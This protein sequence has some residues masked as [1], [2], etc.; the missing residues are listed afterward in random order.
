M[1]VHRS[2][3]DYDQAF[4]NEA[5]VRYPTVDDVED[6]LGYA[7]DPDQLLGAARVLA[8]P[9]K[10]N[11]P[12]WQH[13]RVLYAYARSYLARNAHSAVPM[14]FLDIGTAK[15]F[16]ALC[17]HWALVDSGVHGRVHTVDVV[18]PNERAWRNTVVEIG[19][20][21]P[22]NLTE[23]LDEWPE[24]GNIRFYGMTGMQ[25]LS[26]NPGLQVNFA[27]VDGK[28][29]ADVVRQEARMLTARQSVG[30]VIIFDDVHIPEVRKA[31]E[32]V[33]QQAYTQTV[34]PVLARRAYLV[35]T[36]K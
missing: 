29:T 23:I 16:S 6:Q 8:C 33:T 27:F 35:C 18:H 26:S 14:C 21:H 10:V 13:G 5:G 25:W 32:M 3:V 22:L 36:R 11:P 24:T 20:E 17:M 1:I 9:V 19:C 15:G 31:A 4:R 2:K 12:N 7:I 30:D 28:H 34:I